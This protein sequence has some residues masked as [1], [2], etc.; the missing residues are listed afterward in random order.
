MRLLKEIF[1][2]EGI[3]REG[4]TVFREAV[5]GI[6]LDGRKLLMIYSP[7]NGDY[8]FP[9]GGVDDGETYEQ[10]LIREIKE[11]TGAMVASIDKEFGNIIEYALPLEQDYDV[12]K[13][14]SYYYLCKIGSEFGGQNLDQYEKD[15]DFKPIWIDIDV[16]IRNNQTILAHKQ[17]KAAWTVRETFM[18]EQVKQQLFR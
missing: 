6:I 3:N 16:A 12:F 9:G 10:A 2:N 14:T 5:R 8:K 13:M 7:V 4:R 18:L 1:R 11:E 15:L 17:E